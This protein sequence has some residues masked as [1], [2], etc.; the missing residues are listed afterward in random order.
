MHTRYYAGLY[1]ACCE[2]AKP[3]TG[4][5]EDKPEWNDFDV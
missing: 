3:N 5:Y 2:K 1:I 4:Q